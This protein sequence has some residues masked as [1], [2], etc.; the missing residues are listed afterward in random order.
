MKKTTQVATALLAVMTSSGWGMANADATPVRND[1]SAFQQLSAALGKQP[2][3][4]NE[5]LVVAELTASGLPD[6]ATI[7]NRIVANEQPEQQISAQTSTDKLRYLDQAGSPTVD[8]DSVVYTV[9]G[10]GQTSSAT[11]ANFNKP[12]PVALHAEYATTGEGAKGINPDDLPQADGPVWVTYTLTNTAMKRQ[13]VSW[14]DSQG[15]QTTKEQP[16]FAPFVGS[17]LVTLP[18]GVGLADAG[19]AVVGTNQRGETTLLWNVVL[20]PPMG[21]F[22]EQLKYRITGDSL[23]VPALSMQ[24][25]PVTNDQDPAVGFSADLLSKTVEGNET[26]TNGL[27]SLDDSAAELASAT[28]QLAAGQAKQAQGAAASYSGSRSLASGSNQLADGSDQLASGLKQL[29]GG[30]NSLSSQLPDAVVAT[31]KI[32][33]SVQELAWAIGNEHDKELPFDP[34]KPPK[35]PTLVQLL[36]LT[37][38]A[39]K[40]VEKAVETS[41]K[42]SGES[43]KL[44]AEVVQAHCA[45]PTPTLPEEDCTKLQQAATKSG[46]AA[47]YAAGSV[48]GLKLIDSQLLERILEGLYQVSSALSNGD[49]EPSI[50]GALWELENALRKASTATGQLSSGASSSANG[51]GQL[52]S[53]SNQLAGGASQLSNGLGQLAG[54]ASQLAGGANQLAAGSQQLQQQGTA[55]V[56]KEVIDASSKPASANAYLDAASERAD[57]ATAYP[58]P[59]GM[60]GRV[61]YVY[62]IKTPDQ[63]GGLSWPAVGMGAVFLAAGGVVGAN[64][65]RS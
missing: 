10:P 65:I 30:L 43:A 21:N 1:T 14:S 22:Q 4:V 42:N 40:Q 58:V 11:Q 52:A 60:T 63:H 34:N 2:D 8:G 24:V 16:V 18:Q 49:N 25:V 53:A 17:V 7:V 47:A 26:M 51:A 19:N 15:N 12:L 32:R 23:Q 62:S 61:A 35:H 50:S 57:D 9:G 5:Q 20:Y 6:S 41:A 44:V 54:G 38:E 37:Q 48:A 29:A 33:Q 31:R 28:S 56:L 55:K 36:W 39:L 27:T 59:S 3:F 64:R 45:P 46:I 13:E